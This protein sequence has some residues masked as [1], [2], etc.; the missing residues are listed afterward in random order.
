MDDSLFCPGRLKD[1]V[2]LI[3]GSTAGLGAA[4]AE[5]F[6]REGAKVVIT[7]RS[8]DRGRQMRERLEALGTEALFVTMDVAQEEDVKAAVGAAVDRFGKLTGLVNNAAWIQNRN[9]GPLTE[10]SAETWRKLT[11]VDLDGVFFASKYGLKAIAQAGG[12]AVLNMSSTG[13]IRGQMSSHCYGACKGAIQSLTLQMATYY[14]RYRIRTNC[15]IVGPFDTGEGR[16]RAIVEDPVMGR[17]LRHQYMGRVG[18]PHEVAASAA[19]LMSADASFIN[20]AMLPVDNG[21]TIR[22][23]TAQGAINMADVDPPSND[24]VALMD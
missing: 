12:G 20:G 19:F 17:K 15:L 11:S 21:G 3:T 18:Q 5:R 22:S 8:E 10:L 7:G 2:I 1:D 23:H 6:A 24:W 9:D 4:M 14:S 13:G 16:L